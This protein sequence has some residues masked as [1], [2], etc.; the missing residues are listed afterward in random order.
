VNIEVQEYE[1]I[2]SEVIKYSQAY[3]SSQ[4]I[5]NFTL[6]VED[7]L[8]NFEPTIMVYGTYNAGKSTL[9]NALFGKEEMA[10]TGDAPETSE[11]SEYIY[12]GYK[13]YDTPGINAPQEH[14]DVTNEHLNK[15]ELILFVL[16][17]DGSFE[18]IFIYE[19]ISEI[20]KLNKPILIVLNNKSGIDKG[21]IEEKEQIDKIN[22]NLSKIGDTMEIE[23]IESKVSLCVV[24]AKTALK[25]KLGDKKLLLEKSN[26]LQL[27]N[28]IDRLLADAGKTEVT[29]AL[30]LYIGNF[31]GDTLVQID[32]K[33]DNPEIQKTQELITYIEKLKQRTEV[34]LR[35][36]VLDGVTIA[37]KNLLELLLERDESRITDFINKITQEM[38]E[39]LNTK[40][41]SIYIDINDKVETFN[42]EFKELS[43]TVGLVDR[44]GDGTQSQITEISDERVSDSL[45]A[46]A[47][48]AVNFIP[49]V[50]PVFGFPVPARAIA[51]VALV[52]FSVFTGSNEAQ[53]KAQAQVDEKRQQH[54]SA[55]NKADEFGYDYKN[56]LLL[57]VDNKVAEIFTTTL[58]NLVKLSLQLSSDNKKLLNDKKMLQNIL[59]RL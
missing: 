21:S 56:K 47:G 32:S 24:N 34:E 42:T 55:K 58:N 4:E 53:A 50:V 17:N 44:S 28:D 43:L 12:N 22:L 35:D 48:V 19:K 3:V 7:K 45:K 2:K 31:I 51:Q 33:I 37:S 20:V 54:L 5:E 49:P 46:G 6:H 57:S 8:N 29:N 11:I 18:E 25:A 40:I 30:N 16:S 15:C 38:Q 23:A 52:I 14:E 59:D 39:L 41:K 13:L 26:I 27:E 9:L 10:K 1:E 36:I